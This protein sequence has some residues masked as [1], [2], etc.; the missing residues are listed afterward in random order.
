ML[1]KLQVGFKLLVFLHSPISVCEMNYVVVISSHKTQTRLIVVASVND[2]YSIIITCYL[3]PVVIT[4][5]LSQP[6][7]AV[8]GDH[9]IL[10]L[11]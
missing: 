4:Q 8:Q 5:P 9:K 7:L 11:S 3:A 6:S 2:K 10:S 1:K